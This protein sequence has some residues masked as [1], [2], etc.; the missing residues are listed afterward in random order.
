M[1]KDNM[2]VNKTLL[3]FIIT[4]FILTTGSFCQDFQVS[5]LI[6]IP[7]N[8]YDFDVL[9]P[10]WGNP[11]S[12]TYLCWINNIDSIY[13][14]YLK[15]LSPIIGENI[16]VSSD[17]KFKSRPRIALNGSGKGINV[18]WQCKIDNHWTIYSKNYSNNQLSN[19]INILDSLDND[20]EISLSICRLAWINKGNLM[21][22]EF[23]Q[24]FA[25]IILF[26]SLNCSS[27]ELI[28]YDNLQETMVPGSMIKCTT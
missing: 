14:V 18:V 1:I 3:A 10:E 2:N 22:K 13:T 9:S 24:D 15:Q 17:L 12:D 6:E 11:N 19:S 23:Y 25:D 5:H 21:I 8:N 16:I 28:K 4:Q 20:P 27:P 7:G 26:D